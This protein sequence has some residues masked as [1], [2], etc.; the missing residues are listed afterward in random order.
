MKTGLISRHVCGIDVISNLDLFNSQNSLH[1]FKFFPSPFVVR[2]VFCFEICRSLGEVAE[3]YIR[4]KIINEEAIRNPISFV[5][6]KYAC[7]IYRIMGIY[8]VSGILINF[9]LE[10]TNSLGFSHYST[11]TIS[12]TIVCRCWK[13]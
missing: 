11:R 6:V 8:R 10:A 12:C 4:R 7:T 13:D 1:G 3:F 2:F 9:I 5:I